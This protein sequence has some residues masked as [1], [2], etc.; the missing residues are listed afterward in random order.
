MSK[1]IEKVDVLDHTAARGF[2]ELPFTYFD[3]QNSHIYWICNHDQ[4]GKITSV[5]VST[6]EKKGNERYMGYLDTIEQAVQQRNELILRGWV[7]FK[8]PEI[9]VTQPKSDTFATVSPSGSEEAVPRVQG[10]P[11]LNRRQRRALERK[12]KR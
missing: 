6:K 9:S 4:D 1:P 10:V 12:K 5:Y 8:L 3:P 2:D 7:E 11:Q